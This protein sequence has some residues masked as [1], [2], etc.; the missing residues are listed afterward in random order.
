[1]KPCEQFEDTVVVGVRSKFVKDEIEKRYPTALTEAW[2]ESVGGKHRVSL[3]IS[4]ECG[5]SCSP[6]ASPHGF[7]GDAQNDVQSEKK[8]ADGYA[9]PVSNEAGEGD[10]GL[11]SPLNA[12]HVFDAFV[13]DNENRMACAAAR[14]AALGGV[15]GAPVYIYGPSGC[16]KTHLLHAAARERLDAKPNDRVLIISADALVTSIMG[17]YQD[18]SLRDMK[19]YLRSAD[20]LIVD[21]IHF[22]KGRDGSQEEILNVIDVLAASRK[23]VIVAGSEAPHALTK[24]GLN[25]RLASRLEGGLSVA[26][27]MPGARLRYQI[28]K[29]K[30]DVAVARWGFDP[31]ADEVIQK[32]A[33]TLQVSARELEGAL[34]LL[35]LHQREY[36]GEMS[37]EMTESILK[38]QLSVGA[39]PVSIVDIKDAVADVF[40]VAIPEIEGKRRTQRVMRARHATTFLA[41]T[42]TQEPYVTIGAAIGGRDH[43]TV[44]SSVNRAEA[45]IAKD[46]AFAELIERVRSRLRARR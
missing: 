46:R 13:V 28:L 4:S 35:L 22:L 38:D 43:S 30:L 9:D 36:G 17:A 25:A 21:D 42:L 11:G 20:M 7:N 18:K 1:M 34:R 27:K 40:E 16:G 6:E 41:K 29:A 2:R 33:E 19:R 24:N 14:E 39:G 15:S 5:P 45:L 23:P 12:A 26:V 8:R 32:L 37:V 10:F 44:I 31:V 3:A